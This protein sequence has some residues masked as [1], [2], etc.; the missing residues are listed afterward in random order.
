[1]A[2]DFTAWPFTQ[3]RL[4]VCM[5]LH[6]KRR[7]P[8]RIFSPEAPSFLSCFQTES[9]YIAL[10]GLGLIEINQ[11]AHLPSARW[12]VL[13]TYPPRETTFFLEIWSPDG[14]CSL[15]VMVGW[16]TSKPQEYCLSKA[17]ITNGCTMLSLEHRC[18]GLSLGP[19][20]C[21][22]SVFSHFAS[23]TVITHAMFKIWNR[24]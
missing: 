2:E 15:S 19:H 11:P 12:K 17:G 10:V 6:G 13:A 23:K 7:Q 9:H 5:S 21:M 16:L 22:A 3:C 24:T 8:P 4:A 1:M 20:A 14:S 18:W